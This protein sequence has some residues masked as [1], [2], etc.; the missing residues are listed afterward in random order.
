MAFY[1]PNEL[2]IAELFIGWKCLVKST[3]PFFGFSLQSI[4]NRNRHEIRLSLND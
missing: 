2:S 3:S 4:P 1:T